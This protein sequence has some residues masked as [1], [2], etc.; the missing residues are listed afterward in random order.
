MYQA[1]MFTG[2]VSRNAAYLGSGCYAKAWEISQ[3]VVCKIGMNDGTRN[4]LEFCLLMR[5]QGKL[6]PLMPEVYQ[7]VS[8]EDDRYMATMR[9]YFNGRDEWRRQGQA[10]GDFP[11]EVTWNADNNAYSEVEEAFKA[12]IQS[13]NPIISM[14]FSDVHG[15]NVMWCSERKWIITDPCSSSYITQCEKPE[16]TLQ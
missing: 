1:E 11:S 10:Y 14:G 13:I 15:G 3:G 8:L 7:V 2:G 12:Y 4:W 6:M 16:F 9:R 5:E